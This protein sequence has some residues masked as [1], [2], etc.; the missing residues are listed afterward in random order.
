[1]KVRMKFD[2]LSKIGLK[3]VKDLVGV[4]IGT[5]SVKLCG[6]KNA[7]T[8]FN[9]EKIVKKSFDDDILSDGNI[10]DHMS[11]A[12]EL[13]RM[14]SENGIKNK[15]VACALSSYSVITK[16]VQIPFVEEEELESMVAMEVENVIPF[17]MKEIYYSYY[18]MGVDEEKQDMMN[19]QVVAAKREIVDGYIKVFHA[20]GLDL[21]ILDVDIF[22]LTNLIEQI[23]SPKEVSVLV[24]DI[25][26]WVS[27]IA[28]LKGESLEFTR[29]ILMGG[30]Y[31]TSQIEKLLK[32]SYKEAENKKVSNDSE[33]SYL[34]EDFIFNVS[35]EINKTINFY[36]ATKPRESISRIYLTGGSSLLDG[37][38]KRIAQDNNIEVEHVNPFLLVADD[39]SKLAAYAEHREFMPVALYLSSRVMD[40]GL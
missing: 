32:L 5:S 4:D 29:E 37:L 16:K 23:Y 28:I 21:Q 20:A 9:I 36:L 40:V 30:K 22:A 1:M 24:A 18:V 26:A 12:D 14:F 19:V 33:V 31:L 10:I 3:S 17:P 13:K 15:N 35:S 11:L 7:K 34:F 6:L 25:G 39:E 2:I 27:N 38:D 8:G